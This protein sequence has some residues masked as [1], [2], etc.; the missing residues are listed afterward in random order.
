MSSAVITMQQQRIKIPTAVPTPQFPPPP[1]KSKGLSRYEFVKQLGDGT[2]GDVHLYRTKDTNEMVAIKTMKKKFYN[3]EECVNLREVRSLKKLNHVNVVKLKEVIREDN[4]LYFVFEYMKENLYQ[5]MKGRDKYLPEPSIRNMVYQV[6]QGMAFMHKHGFFHRDMKPEN[7]LCMG[8]EL[9]K[10]ADFGLAREIRSKPPY[11]DYVSTRW[12]RA[13]EVLLRSTNY[14]SPID[15]WAIGCIVAELYTL[16]PLF[17][18]SSEMDEI[19]K[20]CQ[21]LGPPTKADWPEGQN[22]ANQMNFR[23]PQVA[24]VGLKAKVSNA[25]PEA[26]QLITDMVQW[27]PKKRPTASQALRYPYFSVNQDLGPKITQQQA[28][29]KLHDQRLFGNLPPPTFSPSLHQ[30]PHEAKDRKKLSAPKEHSIAAPEKKIDPASHKDNMQS[31]Q[32][33]SNGNN[34][35]LPVLEKRK[36]TLPANKWKQK[37]PT[38]NADESL[39]FMLNISLDGENLSNPPQKKHTAFNQSQKKPTEFKPEPKSDVTKHPEKA[40][41]VGKHRSYRPSPLSTFKTLLDD[42]EVEKIMG[43]DSAKRTLPQYS[44]GRLDSTGSRDTSATKSHKFRP[45]VNY[46]KLPQ[47][48]N[49]L[50]AGGVHGIGIG[51]SN[52]PKG[53]SFHQASETNY[54]PFSLNMDSNNNNNSGFE[55]ERGHIHVKKEVGRRPLGQRNTFWTDV[56]NENKVHD[57]K[58]LPPVGK[59]TTT[60]EDSGS[61]LDTLSHKTARRRW[62][63]VPGVNKVNRIDE[64]LDSNPSGNVG[65]YGKKRNETDYLFGSPDSKLSFA[66]RTRLE[67]GMNAVKHGSQQR[68]G[69]QNYGQ[70]RYLSGIKIK[71]TEVNGWTGNN[72]YHSPSSYKPMGTQAKEY[73]VGAPYMPSFATKKEVG[74]AGQ[75]IQLPVAPATS[76]NTW[77][78]RA[79]GSQIQP[80][81]KNKT[82]P[83]TL[84]PQVVNDR[85]GRTDWKAKYGGPR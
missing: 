64:F 4:Q 21:V 16:K 61:H 2:F 9:V 5:L 43:R 79:I 22:L 19:F 81:V 76:F 3:W 17:P 1:A 78:S 11:T 35:H 15:I 80:A 69:K 55:R 74:S 37:P 26:L 10:I 66:S 38:V 27:N 73:T 29:Q 50:G 45:Q 24:G 31:K 25:S 28:L 52:P 57:V 67:N 51:S 84:R 6:L 14:S 47:V 71:E 54:D 13:P 8:P 82:S 75:R 56:F 33:P 44:H 39:D 85:F 58:P 83:P 32:E 63:T 49:R 48:N 30:S 65:L 42:D 36:V 68:S 23:W 46:R 59:K 77:K 7:L 20:L 70:T 41:D 34:S 40:A 72:N 60:K 53:D 62:R 12:Y 18:G